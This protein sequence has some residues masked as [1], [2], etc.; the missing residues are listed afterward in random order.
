MVISDISHAGTDNSKRPCRIQQGSCHNQQMKTFGE[1]LRYA[2][3]KRGLSQ[4]DLAE[5]LG[6]E[7][8]S[9]S[10]VVR[11][12]SGTQ[13]KANRIEQIVRALDVDGDW[14]LT[15]DGEMDRGEKGEATRQLRVIGKIADGKVS[16]RTLETIEGLH[17]LGPDE[18]VPDEVAQWIAANRPQDSNETARS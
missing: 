16:P 13:P 12:E 2:R 14:L 3:E 8:T 5:R 6:L 15:G 9:A 11:W 4:E 1:R 10:S 18:A 17:R 7:R